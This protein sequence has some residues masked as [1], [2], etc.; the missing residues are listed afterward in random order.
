MSESYLRAGLEH[1]KRR[2]LVSSPF[3]HTCKKTPKDAEDQLEAAFRAAAAIKSA[4]GTSFMVSIS[5]FHP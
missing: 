2:L 1:T 3:S 4:H 5:S